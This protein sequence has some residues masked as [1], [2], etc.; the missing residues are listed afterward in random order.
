M[1]YGYYQFV[2]FASMVIFAF[3]AYKEYEEKDKSIY[4]FIWVVAAILFNPFIKVSLDRY[5]WNVVD[6][7]MAILL[8]ISL[9]I[10]K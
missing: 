8:L 3:L 10:K 5:I 9:K 1:P 2:R 4:F 7:V 6:V